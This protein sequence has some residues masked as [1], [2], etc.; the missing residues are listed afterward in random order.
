MIGHAV[1]VPV[2]AGLVPEN[3]TLRVELTLNN[4]VGGIAIAR[5]DVA[6]RPV[7]RLFEPWKLDDAHLVQ[8]GG[9]VFSSPLLGDL[10]A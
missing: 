2:L 9:P 6:V 3:P 7:G 4:G 5:I 10:S 8:N 1:V